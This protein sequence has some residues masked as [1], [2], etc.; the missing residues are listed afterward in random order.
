MNIINDITL[1]TD[2]SCLG[3][4]GPGGWAAIL[5]AQTSQGPHAEFWQGACPHTTN[6]RMEL[7]AVIAG[8]RQ[9]KRP[10]RV[11]VVTDSQYVVNALSGGK[12]K[13]NEDLVWEL[14][15]TLEQRAH[16][17]EVRQVRGHQ[18]PLDADEAFNA[19]ADALARAMAERARDE[20]NGRSH[21]AL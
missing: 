19:K 20:L 18:A 10:C 17:V 4:P 8:L 15:E 7:A 2:G 6:N 3:N 21:Q 1:Y 5:V 13:A 11:T 9:L 12:M 14:R 16:Q